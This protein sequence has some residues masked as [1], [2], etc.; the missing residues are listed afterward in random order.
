MVGQRQGVYGTI[1]PQTRTNNDDEA[2]LL[3]DLQ[4]R[5]MLQSCTLFTCAINRLKQ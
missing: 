3:L 4:P 5:A 1:P 2:L